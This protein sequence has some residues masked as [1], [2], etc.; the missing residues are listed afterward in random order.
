MDPKNGTR[1]AVLNLPGGGELRLPRLA[2]SCVVK[3]ANKITADRKSKLR[4]NL[5]EAGVDPEKRLRLLNEFDSRPIRRSDIV[6]AIDEPAIQAEVLRLALSRQQG[7]EATNED[8]DAFLDQHP[9]DLPSMIRFCLALLNY[10][11]AEAG[12]AGNP[13]QGDETTSP[14]PTTSAKP[15][16]SAPA[17]T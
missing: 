1:D 4:A 7:K 5:E 15:A 16:E 13:P 9:L 12:A 2:P 8:V 17:S 11:V 14:S 6:G 3:L 10:Q